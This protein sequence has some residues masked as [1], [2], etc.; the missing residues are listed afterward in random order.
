M[1]A[2][3]LRRWLA[4][5]LAIVVL[6]PFG[7]TATITFH[8]LGVPP[9]D[10]T[11]LAVTRLRDGA[12]LWH[13][14]TW[15]EATRA[16]LGKKGLD[17][18]LVENGQEI[19]RST[20]DPYLSPHG[21]AR[22]VRRVDVTGGAPA[23]TAYVYADTVFGPPAAV[24]NWLVP[25]ILVTTL[26]LTLGGAAWF[27]GRTVV[28][29]LAATSRAARQI[30]TGDLD[31]DLPSS[32][33]REVA[34]VN[35]AFA[36]MSGAL[37]TSL[38]QQAT[39]EQERRLFIGAVVHDLRTPLFSLRGYLEGFAK[40]LAD[41]PEKQ[42]RYIAVAQD[43]TAALERLVS[44]LF[45][46][47]RLEYLDQAPNREPLD[48]AVLLQR[49]VDDLGPL[50]EAKGIHLTLDVPPAPCRVD[51]DAHM[52]TRAVENLLDNA[53]RYTPSG[54]S[55][56]TACTAEPGAVTFT[57]VDTGP[58]IPAQDVPHLFTPLYRGETSRN[59]R[60]GGAGLGL[61]IARRIFRAHGGEL[62]AR[63]GDTGGAVFTASLPRP[64]PAR[65]SSD[66]GLAAIEAPDR[67]EPATPAAAVPTG[68]VR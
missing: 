23:R 31:V 63:N 44:D 16:E 43:K 1:S 13:D 19:Y 15:Q 2:L 11:A 61:A 47:T 26:A 50:A 53:L 5:A 21:K 17:F 42:A 55:V 49:L 25:I 62:T 67:G 30:A 41:T 32:R 56:R 60:T 34:E 12:S 9:E 20:A 4:L 59:R 22:L 39:M 8:V 38:Q 29:P 28:A 35:S 14:Q 37:R 24:R 7:V 54:G 45:A 33:V 46:F 52:L 48:L 65:A 18:L 57:I 10:P 64:E 6:I 68:G 36:A 40:G 27:F 58:G 3:P 51:G 66:R